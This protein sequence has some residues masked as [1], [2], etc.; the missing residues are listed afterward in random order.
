MNFKIS[1]NKF[2]NALQI[3]SRA[4]SP[5]SPVPSLC[6]V[7]IEAGNDGITLTG[8]DGDISI[9]MHLS[10]T[11]DENLNLSVLE[12]GSVIQDILLLSLLK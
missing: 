1:K 2:Y 10:N 11:I 4:I 8:S 3:V 5:N 9:R 12:E 6:G 7:L